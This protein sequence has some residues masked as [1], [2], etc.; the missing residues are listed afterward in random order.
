MNH[1]EFIL[2]DFA[3]PAVN[4]IPEDN[5]AAPMAQ[6]T[7]SSGFSSYFSSTTSKIVL[8]VSIVFSI[9]VVYMYFQK[10]NTPTRIEMPKTEHEDL[11][12]N[13]SK[14]E[15]ENMLCPQQPVVVPKLPVN[16]LQ[17][18]KSLIQEFAYLKEIDAKFI[19]TLDPAG[20][21]CIIT[22]KDI[23]EKMCT[24]ESFFPG[25]GQILSLVYTKRYLAPPPV[26]PQPQPQPASKVEVLDDE[27][28][29]KEKQKAVSFNLTNADS[30]EE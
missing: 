1:N 15:L 2:P 12:K 28:A 11:L 24:E 25:Q 4:P 30:D 10:K 16:K 7:T 9:I 21:T 27:P 17:T 5:I 18:K 8:F 13:T 19:L 22:A 3:V 23:F 26:Q 20:A 29:Q 14:E 6:T